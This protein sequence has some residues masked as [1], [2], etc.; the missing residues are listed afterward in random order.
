MPQHEATG[1]GPDLD[2]RRRRAVWTVWIVGMM[3]AAIFY[4]E[5]AADSRSA[6]IRWRHQ[7]H[8]LWQGKNIWDDYLFP[9]PPIMPLTL[10]PL[11]ALPPVVGAVC[12]FALKVAMTAVAI[13]LCFRMAEGTGRK[14]P[15]WGE[16]FVLLLS[17][18]PI[19][20]DLLHGNINLLIL[21]CIVV[22]LEAWRRGYDVL[23]GLAL[24]AAISYKVTPALFVPYFFYKR[25]YRTVFATMLGMGLFLLVVPSLVLG[26]DFNWQCL[27]MWY[28]RILRPYV[29]SNVVGQLE[30]NQSMVGVMMRLLTEGPDGRYGP[31]FDSNLVSWNPQEVA[32]VIKIISVGLVG[33]LAWLCRTRTDRRLDPRLL[34]E[35]SLVVL[36]MLFVSE[37]S[38]KN[39]YVTLLLPYVY[40]VYRVCVAKRFSRLRLSLLGSLLLSAILMATTSEAFGGQVVEQ[41]HKIALGYGLFF[42]SGVVLYIATAWRVFVER[43]EPLALASVPTAE[44]EKHALPAPHVRSKTGVSSQAH[45]SQAS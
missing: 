11:M 22:T 38:W 14:F 45:P 40:L 28:H 2:S 20:S 34:G 32:R 33:L 17:V 7:V 1:V 8:E 29:T 39:H 5:K 18:R 25:S 10:S 37:R 42:W 13:Q 27:T 12:W 9:N 35:F 16:G 26:I 44:Q 3:I 41:G 15:W 19:L 6:F 43:K 30:I 21:F 24:A 23:A 36:T 4:A 31:Q